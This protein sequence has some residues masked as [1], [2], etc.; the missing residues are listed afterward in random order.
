[1]NMNMEMKCMICGMRISAAKEQE[2]LKRAQK[3]KWVKSEDGWRCPACYR[4]SERH[5]KRT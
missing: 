4:M 3:Q 5:K 2:L 1:M